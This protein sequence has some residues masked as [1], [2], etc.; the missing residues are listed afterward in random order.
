MWLRLTWNVHMCKRAHT[1]T[2]YHVSDWSLALAYRTAWDYMY[3]LGTWCRHGLILHNQAI[4]LTSHTKYTKIWPL[5]S[6]KRWYKDTLIYITDKYRKYK[7]TPSPCKRTE[8]QNNTHHIFV[9]MQ[10][11]IGATHYLY[12]HSIKENTDVLCLWYKQQQIQPH[13]DICFHRHTHSHT[14]YWLG[15]SSCEIVYVYDV[16]MHQFLWWCIWTC[17]CVCVTRIPW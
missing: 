17:V 3:C 16:F 10:I 9:F 6:H 8:F 11:Q 15:D 1:E 2:P 14:H 12:I 13:R 7:L 5:F 4:P